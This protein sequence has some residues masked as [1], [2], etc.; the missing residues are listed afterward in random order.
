MLLDA[1]K[2]VF[3]DI[4]EC[5]FILLKY[6]KKKDENE[7]ET[8]QINRTNKKVLTNKVKFIAATVSMP[9]KV[10]VSKFHKQ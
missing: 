4:I 5:F 1:F 6:I 7:T 3:M 8:T 9:S 10:H 2:M